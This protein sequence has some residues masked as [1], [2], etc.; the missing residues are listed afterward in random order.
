MKESLHTPGAKHNVAMKNLMD[1]KQEALRA[2]RK[3]GRN[4]DTKAAKKI[5][6]VS[7][8]EARKGKARSR[9]KRDPSPKKIRKEARQAAKHADRQ[10]AKLKQAAKQAARKAS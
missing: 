10:A 5:L 6:A 9:D 1:K 2:K 3:Q 8:D 4:V 7:N